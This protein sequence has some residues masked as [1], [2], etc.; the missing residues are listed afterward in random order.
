MRD[1]SVLTLADAVVALAEEQR[2][3][4]DEQR[5]ANAEMSEAIRAL[6]AHVAALPAPVVNVTTDAPVVQDVRIVGLPPMNARV[7]RD[8]AGRI[9]SIEE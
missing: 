7:R 2:R 1:E 8:R 4:N 5:R 9:E 6:A 3:A